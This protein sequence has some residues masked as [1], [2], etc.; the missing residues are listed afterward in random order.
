MSERA[1]LMLANC[2]MLALL[3]QTPTDAES[4]QELFQF[5]DEQRGYYS[6]VPAGQGLL[7]MGQV[8]IPFDN[9]IPVDTRMYKVFS[10]KPGEM[11]DAQQ[12]RQ[13]MS[14]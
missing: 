5:S 7:K 12:Y 9:S 10:T 11:I 13:P 4:L 2:D 6:H 8:V 14:R 3:N 1:R